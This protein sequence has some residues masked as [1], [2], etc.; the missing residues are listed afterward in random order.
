MNDPLFSK[1]ASSGYVNKREDPVKRK[2][3]KAYVITEN[4][5]SSRSSNSCPLSQRD[6]NLDKCEN[7]IKKSTEDRSKIFTMS[8]LYYECYVSI[9]SGYNSRNC[10]QRKVCTICDERQPTGLHGYKHPSKSKLPDV[11]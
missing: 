6:D 7:F 8:K 5:N 11:Q 4:K 10:K 2:Q 1:E 3:L 9:Y